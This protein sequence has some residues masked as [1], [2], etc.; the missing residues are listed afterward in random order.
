MNIFKKRNGMN[1]YIKQKEALCSL[2]REA[3]KNK[4]CFDA[5]GNSLGECKTP[6][7]PE[8][9]IESLATYLIHHKVRVNIK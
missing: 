1:S 3:H 5:A 6:I 8:E 2:L 7:V 9:Y 4:E